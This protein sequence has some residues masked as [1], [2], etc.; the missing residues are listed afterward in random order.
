M[1]TW[2]LLRG[3]ARDSRHWDAFPALLASVLP[4]DARIVALDLPGNGALRDESSPWSID[5]MVDACRTPLSLRANPGPVHVMGLSMGAM[6]AAAWARRYPGELASAV[7]VNGSAGRVSPP[8]HRLRPQA[9]PALLRLSLPATGDEERERRIVALCS[10]LADPDRAALRWAGYARTRRASKANALRQLVAAAR[11]RLPPAPPR[12]PMLVVASAADRLV[13]V[14]CSIA[15][16]RAWGLPI[17][18]HPAAGHELALDDPRWLAR[19]C[20]RWDAGLRTP[21]AAVTPSSRVSSG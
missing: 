21:A 10:N 7:L 15:L 3:L 17:V 8:W 19:Q 4:P 12:V 13:S 14:E 20:A 11:Y 9:W 6:V 2:V 18:L 5:A 1:S 16:A